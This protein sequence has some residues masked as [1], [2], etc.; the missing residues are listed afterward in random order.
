MI[1]AIF[2]VD[3]QGGMGKGG[4]LPCDMIKKICNGLVVIHVG[5]LL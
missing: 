2:A 5:T 4:S 1:K 3:L